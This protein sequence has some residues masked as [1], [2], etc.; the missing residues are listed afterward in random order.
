MKYFK[1]LTLPLKFILS[2]SILAAIALRLDQGQLE[3]MVDHFRPVA[4]LYAIVFITAQC[5]LLSLRWQFLLNIGKRHVNFTQS[6]QVNLVS[7]L[8]N[9]VFIAS[10][11]GV[12]ARVALSIQHGA[13]FFKSL[14]ATVFDRFM[15]LSALL[16]LAALFLPGLAGHVDNKMFTTLL[17]YICVFIFAMFVFAPV[18]LN[19]VF[20]RLPAVKKL[21]GHMRYGVR[22]L[23]IL[24]NS[25][26]LLARFVSVSLIAQ[27][28]FFMAVYSLMV[29]SGIELTLLQL[30]TVLPVI[31]FVAALPISIGGWGV[32]EG[33]FVYGLG[34]LGISMENAFLI[35]V[36]IGLIGMLTT[37]LLGLPSLMTFK[38]DADKFASFKQGLAWIRR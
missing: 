17:G 29:M 22:Y 23:K 1:R 24:S 19:T 25:P 7:Q 9:L 26:A 36:Q 8:A 12:V 5:L 3:D 31:C 21:K 27:M 11:G 2:V 28:C 33:A 32:R 16:V 37:I 20:Y 14:I 35:S 38:F 13:S 6:V 4:W 18:F 15:S 10:I 34:L 30:M